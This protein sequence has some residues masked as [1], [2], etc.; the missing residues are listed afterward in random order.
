VANH[1]EILGVGRSASSAEVKKAYVRLARERHP[2]R[3]NDPEERKRADDSFKD[4]TAAFNTLTDAE[5]RAK[6]DRELDNPEA[7]SPAAQ[8]EDAWRRGKQAIDAGDPS[9][10]VELLRA[11]AHLAPD[12]HRY[13]GT[14]AV[15]LS[16]LQGG[17]REAIQAVEAALRLAPK[18][19]SYLVLL[20]R[21]QLAQGLKLR[22]RKSIEQALALAPEDPEVQKLAAKLAPSEP[23]R[24]A[25]AKPASGG[26]SGLFRRR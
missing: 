10:A 5:A 14:L 17:A 13:H 2:D 11:A 16:G 6:Y 23:D 4:L 3:F 26:L 20:A 24:D 9:T 25:E 1:Y 15:A 22:A 12:E 7:M 19:T 8:A 21:M 18:Q